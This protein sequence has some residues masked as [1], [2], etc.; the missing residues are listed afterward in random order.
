[1]ATTIRQGDR[2]RITRDFRGNGLATFD[3]APDEEFSYVLPEGCILISSNDVDTMASGFLCVLESQEVIEAVVPAELQAAE[4]FSGCRF[5]F[6][7]GDQGS[8]LETL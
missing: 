7:T 6:Y 5:V 4:G 2:F 1:M 3:D 8:L